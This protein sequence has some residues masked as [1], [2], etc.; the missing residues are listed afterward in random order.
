MNSSAL[1]DVPLCDPVNRRT[2]PRVVSGLRPA[3]H[4]VHRS[5]DVRFLSFPCRAPAPEPACHRRAASRRSAHDVATLPPVV[6]TVGWSLLPSP[7]ASSDPVRPLPERRFLTDDT[8][9]GDR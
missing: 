6:R 4:L 9:A 8:M 5:T 2:T 1:G 7:P 3:D